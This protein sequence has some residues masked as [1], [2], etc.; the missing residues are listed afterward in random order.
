MR[1]SEARLK[2]IIRQEVEFRL[3]ESVL[4][5]L[6]VEELKK[7]GINEEDEGFDDYR[8]AVKA[9]TRRDFLKG[10]G[11][12]LGLGALGLPLGLAQKDAAD[13]RGARMD[14]RR[15]DAF[16]ERSTREYKEQELLEYLNNTAAFRW[17]RGNQSMM[18]VP[19]Q[20]VRT[21]ILP[22]SYTI[23]L[24]ALKNK[25]DGTPIFAPPDE[26]VLFTQGDGAAAKQ[27]LESFFEDYGDEDFIDYSYAFETDGISRVPGGG[28]EKRMLMV[29][30]ESISPDY[31]LPENGL[32][33]R[34]YYNW[35]Y[36]NQ[37]LSMDEVMDARNY[38]IEMAEDDQEYMKMEDLFT[39]ATPGAWKDLL[40]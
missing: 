40:K 24:Q 9:K 10:A 25:R 4:D 16:A 22:V 32:T 12:A 7:M 27:N 28:L 37:F 35:I 39:Q 36:Y 19:D 17:G 15:K 26:Q 11:A 21:G 18:Q 5:S 34:E 6:I 14:Q 13:E 31:V 1:L 29:A 30:P 33:A 3:I 38:D 8:Q 23:A 2:E 20:D